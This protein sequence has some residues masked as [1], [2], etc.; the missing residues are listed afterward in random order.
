[1]LVVSKNNRRSFDFAQDD[2]QKQKQKQ[3]QKHQQKQQQQQMQM[4]EQV[5]FKQPRPCDSASLRSGL[6]QVIDLG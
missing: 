6:L 1:V 2:N 3:K 4:R 5:P